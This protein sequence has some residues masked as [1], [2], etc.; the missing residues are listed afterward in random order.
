MQWNDDVQLLDNTNFLFLVF[1]LVFSLIQKAA[2]L[3]QVFQ[4]IHLLTIMELLGKFNYC[5]VYFG[6]IHFLQV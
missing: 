4:L 1:I 6:V 2:L 3:Q 5:V